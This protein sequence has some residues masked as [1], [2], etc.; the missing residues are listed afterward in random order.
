[1]TDCAPALATQVGGNHY[2]RMPMQPVEFSLA[3]ELNTA[4]ANIIKYVCRHAEKGG[5]G[6]LKKAAHYC[7]LWLE[8][9]QRYDLSWEFCGVEWREIGAATCIPVSHF[10]EVN[11]LPLDVARVVSLVCDAPTPARVKAARAVIVVMLMDGYGE[12]A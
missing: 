4:Q 9:A 1:M 2:K 10:V 11:Q 12:V 8:V 5:A 7:D 3:N 6:D